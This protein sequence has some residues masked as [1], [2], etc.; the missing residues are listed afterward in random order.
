MTSNEEYDRAKEVKQFDESKKGVKGLLDSGLTSIPRFFVH[1]PET[2][3]DLKPT[4]DA[5]FVSIPI[6]DL[7]GL[8]SGRRTA[9]VDQVSHAAKNHGFFQIINHGIPQTTMESTI[10]AIKAFFEQPSEDKERFYRR[11]LENGVKYLSNVDLYRSKAASWR[12]SLQ[13]RMGPTRVSPEEIPEICAKEMGQW[14]KEVVQLGEVVLGLVGEGLGLSEGR[15]TELTCLEGRSVVGHYYPFCPEPDRTVGLAS[16][17][18]P[19]VLTVL[20]QDQIGGLQV[21]SGGVWTDVKP[22]PGAIVI[23]VGDLL[24]VVNIYS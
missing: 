16:H 4:S 9:I 10:A 14:D 6:I 7:S 20:M 11:E 21:K 5:Q 15:L 1:P 2:L 24:Q 8:N 12:D 22:V 18:D 3:I 19:T 13:V 23:N 17:A